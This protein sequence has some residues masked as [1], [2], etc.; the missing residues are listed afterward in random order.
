MFKKTLGALMIVLMMVSVASAMEI[1]EVDLPETLMA[2]DKLLVLNGAGTRNV[3]FNDVYVAGLWL[4]SAKTDGAAVCNAEESMIIRMHVINDFF[5][6][7]S[8][9]TSAFKKGFRYA[10]PRG[11]IS[12]I[13]EEMER[14]NAAFAD[15]IKDHE[16]FD[17]VYIPGKGTSI[18]KEG[19][20]KDTIPGYEFKKLLF[21]IWLSE[22]A[23]VN[24]DLTEG[25]LAGKVSKKARAA[26][27]KWIAS[28]KI[29]KGKVEAEAAAKAAAAAEAKMKAE[30]T[31]KA[32]EAES[33]AAAAAEAEAIKMADA[34]KAADTRAKAVAAEKAAMA[35]AAKA[36]PVA[37]AP[38]VREMKVASTGVTKITEKEFTGD[39][40]FFNKNSAALNNKSKKALKLKASWL[41][42]NPGVST[43]IEVSCDSR[44]S[45]EYNFKL[46]KRRATSVVD[47]MMSAGIGSNRMYMVIL[48][49]DNI[50]EDAKENE[51]TWAKS[52]K[53]HFSLK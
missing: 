51:S 37:A 3:F 14:L 47:Y 45:R 5:A 7:S 16:E 21:G 25:M 18:Y 17:I 46:A 49:S 39:D 50:P 36:V 34:K 35:T 32:A 12:S 6:S 19:E 1:D 43:S 26:K 15:E 41:K 13:R 42:A 53:A 52:R 22:K 38:P 20:L 44:G 33:M 24:D 4:E 48:G 30:A 40:I 31:A 2:G 9:I 11:D 10:M 29:D 28:V 27:E 23:T 8:N